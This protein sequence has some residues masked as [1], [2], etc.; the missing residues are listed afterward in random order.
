MICV[1][2]AQY[3]SANRAILQLSASSAALDLAPLSQTAQRNSISHLNGNG[4]VPEAYGRSE[5]RT[6]TNPTMSLSPGHGDMNGAKGT[7]SGSATPLMQQV[8]QGIAQGLS[9]RRGS[10]LSLTDPLSITTARSVPATPLPGGPQSA[11]LMSK[12]PGTPISGEGPLNGMLSA[13][14]SPQTELTPSLQRLPSGGYDGYNMMQSD[15]AMQVRRAVLTHVF[16]LS[17]WTGAVRC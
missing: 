8:S 11:S 5:R 13:Q 10:P 9:S 6:V 2:I 17:D 15:D 3:V 14:H 1:V 16:L 4:R 7:V 12:A